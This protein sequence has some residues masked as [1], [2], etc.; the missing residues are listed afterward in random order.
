VNRIAEAIVSMTSRRITH[1]ASAL[2]LAKRAARKE[3]Q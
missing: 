1:D 3:E 2:G